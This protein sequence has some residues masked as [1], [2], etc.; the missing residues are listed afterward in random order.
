MYS[1]HTLYW[2]SV[3]SDSLE[4]GGVAIAAILNYTS[5]IEAIEEA[6]RVVDETRA[7]L[8]EVGV[9]SVRE[10]EGRWGGRLVSCWQS[11]RLS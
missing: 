6:L 5:S 1:G 8:E 3:L 2:Y 9:W 10:E 11:L 7:V 4:A